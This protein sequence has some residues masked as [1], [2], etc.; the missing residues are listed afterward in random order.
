MSEANGGISRYGMTNNQCNRLLHQSHHACKLIMN[1]IHLDI[2]KT[3]K[4]SLLLL[5]AHPGAAKNTISGVHDGKLKVHVTAAPDKGKANSAIIKL[6]S[7]KLK[8]PKKNLE[9]VKGETSRQK[10]VLFHD[11]SSDELRDSLIALLSEM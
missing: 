3:E 10:T 8:I 2:K 6:L 7:A 5:K 1:N 4:G 9:I 11:V